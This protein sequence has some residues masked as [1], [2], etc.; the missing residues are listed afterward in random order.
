MK[1]IA[2]LVL[3]SF[4]GLQLNAQDGTSYKA[5]VESMDK[6]IKSR[7]TGVYEFQFPT[8]MNADEISKNAAYYTQYFTVNHEKNSGKVTITMVENTEKS[9]LVINR[10]FISNGVRE[11]A[12]EG[13]TYS[14]EKFY[15]DF[16]K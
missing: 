12:M 5:K 10:F 3:L 14:V 9:R 8:S 1:K 7:N 13:T 4:F 11:I 6:I 2:L 15:E 16:L